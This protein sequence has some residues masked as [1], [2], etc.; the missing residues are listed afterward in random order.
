M[1]CGRTFL[2][3]NFRRRSSL[4]YVQ[5]PLLVQ[6][7]AASFLEEFLRDPF[8]PS[9]LRYR[10]GKGLPFPVCPS[11]GPGHLQ[12]RRIVI[13]G[14]ATGSRKKRGGRKGVGSATLQPIIQ[15]RPIP[16]NLIVCEREKPP[17]TI[18]TRRDKSRKIELGVGVR[19]TGRIKPLCKTYFAT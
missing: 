7:L 15:P 3:E 14:R 9:F 10:K 18:R 6:F 2:D 8:R 11:A 12:S 17:M 16:A 4:N 19:Y 5:S 1:H 13:F